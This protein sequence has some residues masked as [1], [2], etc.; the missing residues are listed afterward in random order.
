MILETQSISQKMWISNKLQTWE[1]ELVGLWEAQV[2]V[3][4]QVLEQG[5]VMMWHVTG[6]LVD[7]GPPWV[8]FPP[9]AG[10]LLRPD[11]SEHILQQVLPSRMYMTH[12]T[13][14]GFLS[15]TRQLSGFVWG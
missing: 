6:I 13:A 3:W 11:C 12:L 4:V 14:A 8:A 2:W 7:R 10:P 5:W 9:A 1:A 15:L